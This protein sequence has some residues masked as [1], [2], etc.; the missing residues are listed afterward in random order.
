MRGAPDS[1][2]GPAAVRVSLGFCIRSTSVPALKDKAG[3]SLC[4]AHRTWGISIAPANTHL[5]KLVT[6]PLKLG[7][8]PAAQCSRCHL[9]SHRLAD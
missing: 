3:W 5:R 4:S 9:E 7:H 8:W 1:Q 6:A 2:G